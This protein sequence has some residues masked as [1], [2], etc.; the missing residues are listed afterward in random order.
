[1]AE[2]KC[3]KCLQVK[4]IKEFRKQRKQ[5]KECERENARNYK[6]KNKKYISEYN[7]KYKAENKEMIKQYN[8][9]YWGKNKFELVAKNLIRKKI[10]RKN[11]VVFRL[12]ENMRTRIRD[13]MI[14]RTKSKKTLELL[15]CTFEQFHKWIKWQIEYFQPDLNIEEYG[16]KWHIDH[17]IPV[18][19]FRLEITNEQERCFH[20]TNLQPLEA[21]ENLRKNNKI[22]FTDLFKH[23]L[24]VSAFLRLNKN[25][26]NNKY[27][28]T[29][30]LN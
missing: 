24:K 18:A 23:E 16:Q 19:K 6:L 7:K 11:D 12:S 25:Y 22:K 10:R 26:I 9:N 5:C 13:I 28:L 27:D 30:Y 20:W 2:N 1:M 14:G 3:S 29:A 15:G 8:S 17:V 21:K 4:D